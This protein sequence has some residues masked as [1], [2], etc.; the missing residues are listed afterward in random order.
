MEDRSELEVAYEGDRPSGHGDLAVDSG[1][2]PLVLVLQVGS[3][4]P[5]AAAV[6]KD[7]SR[8]IDNRQKVVG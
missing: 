4:A 1:Q 7:G 5:A 8:D 3:V 6:S 2:P